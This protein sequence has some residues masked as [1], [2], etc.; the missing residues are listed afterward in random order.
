MRG[1]FGYQFQF[2]HH[3]KLRY[4]AIS[5]EALQA[6]S[7]NDSDSY[8]DAYA[9]HKKEINRKA[10]EIYGRGEHRRPFLLIADDFA[11]PDAE[12]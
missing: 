9:S 3:G 4:A 10:C 8:E 11:K 7:G 5:Y 1:S 12:Q 2:E 6:V